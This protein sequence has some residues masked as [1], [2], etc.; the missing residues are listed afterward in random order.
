[1]IE[2]AKNFFCLRYSLNCGYNVIYGASEVP[3]EKYAILLYVHIVHEIYRLV[4]D[5]AGFSCP[6]LALRQS[7][8]GKRTQ[9]EWNGNEVEVPPEGCQH[10]ADS[11][12]MP[13]DIQ[14]SVATALAYDHRLTVA[15]TTINALASSR[16]MPTVYG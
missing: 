15:D 12:D 14:K 9:D 1:V 8:M 10:Y 5:V 16:D 3:K 4:F 7:I 6:S 13:W 11:S 2:A